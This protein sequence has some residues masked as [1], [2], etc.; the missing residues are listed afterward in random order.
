MSESF[1][2]LNEPRYAPQIRIPGFNPAGQA[3]LSRAK[4]LVV[5][6]GGLGSPVLTY[7]AA[8]GVACPYPD[9]ADPDLV[10]PQPCANHQVETPEA[11]ATGGILGIADGDRVALSN[12]PRQI[13]HTRE[14]LGW[15]KA[16]SAAARLR[17]L[18]PQLRVQTH[19]RLEGD[20]AAAVIADY[21][22]VVDATDNFEAKYLLS[23]V[24][25]EV[26]R[27]LVWGTLVSMS[28]QVS[29][30]DQG[31]CLRDLYPVMPQPGTTPAAAQIGVL[32]PVC[33]QAGSIMASEVIKLLTGVGQPLIGRLLIVD[34]GAG[35]W[36]TVSFERRD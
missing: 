25:K 13:L 21:D 1:N 33:G 27:P 35:K 24:C 22:V 9:P 3:A 17:D 11:P 23:D 8:A 28:F 31:Y 12:L 6:A 18:Q 10:A 26:G 7:L 2:P 19:G 29:V 34:A 15:E 32:G 30:F 36:N 14:R 16:D 4:V 5:G 20:R